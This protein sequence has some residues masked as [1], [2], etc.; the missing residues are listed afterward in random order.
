MKEH[1]NPVYSVKTGC[2]SLHKSQKA[3]TDTK[4]VTILM[5]PAVGWV[6]VFAEISRMA[7]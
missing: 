4:T 1:R 7:A 6:F 3:K 5:N 2:I